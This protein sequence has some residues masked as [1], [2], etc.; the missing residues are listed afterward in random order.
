VRECVR[1]D[2]PYPRGRCVASARTD[3][4]SSADSKIRLWVK[5]RPRDK[6]GRART[7]EW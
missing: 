3:F 5:S 2:A 6:C 7:S 1:A 4:F